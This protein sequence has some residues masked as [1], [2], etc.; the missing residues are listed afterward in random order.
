[1]TTF[2]KVGSGYTFNSMWS[3]HQIDASISR[4]MPTR[5]DGLKAQIA[6][7]MDDVP[8]CRSS[9]TLTSVSGMDQFWRKLNR[10]RNND[11]YGVDWE[12]WVEELAGRVLDT[13]RQGQPEIAVAD[14]WD[15]QSEADIWLVEP[16][17]LRGSHNVLYGDPGTA[18]SMMALFWATLMDT[19]HI[20]SSA[21]G[22][23]T[24][25]AH[26]LYLDWETTQE[27]AVRRLRW[28]HEAMGIS[29]PSGVLYRYCTQPLVAEVDRIQDIIQR[30][31][32]GDDT[33]VV[34]ICDSQGLATGGRLVDEEQVISYFAA[35]RTLTEAEADTSLSITHTNKDGGL[36]GSQYTLAAARNLWEIKRSSLSRGQI[37]VG[38]FHRKA[39]TVGLSGPRAYQ[40]TFNANAETKKTASVSITS[41][42][43]MDTEVAPQGLSVPE[44]TYQV[45]RAEGPLRRDELPALVAEYKE[46]RVEKIQAAVLVALSRHLKGGRL[47]EEDGMI[48]MPPSPSGNNQPKAEQEGDLWTTT[49]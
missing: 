21:H 40:L 3:G 23:A 32:G 25:R 34:I 7:L 2:Q 17:V 49:I 46:V 36:F 8:I 33:P 20:D 13:H 19:G 47:L 12:A 30:R 35:L 48:K 38:L 37:D 45:V 9:P 26:C 28:L 10:R 39:N 22:L 11:D 24:S 29:A 14:L 15:N 6:V 18:K 42:R 5:D 41:K 4:L 16:F 43:V 1:M 27:E 31:W 44:L